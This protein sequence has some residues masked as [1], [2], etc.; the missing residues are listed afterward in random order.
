[1]PMYDY[2]CSNESCKED[3]K[4]HKFEGIQSLAKSEEPI[5][6]DKCGSKEYVQK[7]LITPITKSATWKV[8]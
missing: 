7:V 5:E 2:E 4:P 6:C 8:F 1:M 3:N